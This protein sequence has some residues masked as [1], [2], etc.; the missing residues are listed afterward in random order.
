MPDSPSPHPQFSVVSVSNQP[1]DPNSQ[2]SVEK[3]RPQARERLLRTTKG[4]PLNANQWAHC[5]VSHHPC[6]RKP[7]K[8]VPLGSFC[9]FLLYYFFHVVFLGHPAR[10]ME[11]LWLAHDLDSASHSAD[12][13][14]SSWKAFD[15]SIRESFRA[16]ATVVRCLYVTDSYVYSYPTP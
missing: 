8:D 10:I 4:R 14:G 1:Q 16:T 3:P 7:D 5:T 2:P 9:N 15:E 6:H 13:S 12:A 11:R